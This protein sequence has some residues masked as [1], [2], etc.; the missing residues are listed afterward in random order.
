[1][2][3]NGT[4]SIDNI[5]LPTD[6]SEASIGAAAYALS[7]ARQYK[8]RLYC[9]HVVDVSADAAGFYVPH[10]SYENLDDEMLIAAEEM[11]HDFS[12]KNLKGHKNIELRVVSGDPY[13]E[14]VKSIKILKI[15]MCVMGT[16]GKAAIERFF[17]GSTTERVMRKAVCPVLI[18]PPVK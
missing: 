18:V 9:L 12:L 6:F 14:I 7:M 8:A 15:N 2:A 1:M 4:V 10:Q 11:L 3:D 17:V 16:F 5:L 13:K